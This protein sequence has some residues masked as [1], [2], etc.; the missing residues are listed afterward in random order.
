MC[1]ERSSPSC[2]SSSVTRRSPI[3]VRSTSKL[4]VLVVPHQH[5]ELDLGQQVHHV[6]G[7]AI[8]LGVSLLTAEP[9]DLG[10]RESL[11]DVI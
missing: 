5:L 7:P 6:L 11:D 10:H 3:T 8:E 1:C 4:E 2:S 9:L